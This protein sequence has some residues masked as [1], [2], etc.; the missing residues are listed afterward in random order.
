MKLNT[1]ISQLT[2]EFG[3]EEAILICLFVMGI[4]YEKRHLLYAHSEELTSGQITRID[5]ICRQRRQ[6]VP[7]AY[8]TGE[9]FFYNL[10]L[11]VNH[12][13][14]IPRQDT[15]T[16][17]EA[18]LEKLVKL[19][20]PACLDMATGSGAV[21]LALKKELP[22]VIAHGSDICPKA[23]S[24]AQSNV[25]RHQLDVSLHLSSWGDAFDDEQF[26][27]ITA[28]PPYIA[29]TELALMNKETSYEPSLALF[30]EE[31]GLAAYKA[32]AQDA[33][34]LLKTQGWLLVEHGFRQS[35]AVQALFTAAGL[36]QVE[37]ITDLQGHSRVTKGQ[38]V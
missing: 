36:T 16:L 26:H 33:R 27:V 21:I 18:A 30:A 20:Q 19:E 14:L 34:R 32:I 28:N 11:N 4:E 3:Q 17:V 37:T 13:C 5:N 2:D 35:E 10:D 9:T 7:L 6:A 22:T 12:A 15:E 1:L 8:I 29:H 31:N 25:D 38:K 23:I 24:V